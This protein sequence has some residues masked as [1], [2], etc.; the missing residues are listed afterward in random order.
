MIKEKF[1]TNL[2]A[3]S[4]NINGIVARIKA[5]RKSTRDQLTILT[6]RSKRFYKLYNEM[7]SN[8]GN[9]K[10]RSKDLFNEERKFK[11]AMHY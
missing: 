11:H 9:H 3:Y 5:K 4:N 8:G 6:E 10:K 2:T 1:E 7:M